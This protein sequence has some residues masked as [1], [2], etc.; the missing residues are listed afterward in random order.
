MKVTVNEST[1]IV[2]IETDIAKAVME[3]AMKDSATLKDDK[4]NDLFRLE[5]TDAAVGGVNT[6]GIVCN[7]EV[8]GNL[9]VTMVLP[10]DEA[11]KEAVKKTMGVALVKAKEMLPKLAE[12]LAKEADALDA[13]F[14]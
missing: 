8:N 10:E 4:G 6:C 1:N 13:I 14:A 9:A 3:R 7:A 5:V 11:T 2:V 12:Q